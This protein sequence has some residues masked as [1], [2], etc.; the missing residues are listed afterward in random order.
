[1]AA[2]RYHI[3]DFR[4]AATEAD[5]ASGGLA[6]GLIRR[7]KRTVHLADPIDRLPQIKLTQRPRKLRQRL[8]IAMDVRDEPQARH[9][10][11]LNCSAET[12]PPPTS[13]TRGCGARFGDSVPSAAL[14]YLAGAYVKITFEPLSPAELSAMWSPG[15]E[16]AIKLSGEPFDEKE[17]DREIE[18]LRR[19][20]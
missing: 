9:V 17:L 20:R 14:R 5:N 7:C 10:N 13:S 4:V 8:R 3:R 18:H 11:H 19:S 16:A 2:K 6:A 1:L 15:V 12:N